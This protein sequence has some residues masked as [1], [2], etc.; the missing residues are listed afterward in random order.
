MRRGSG[1]EPMP[2]PA[3]GWKSP[4][5]R[6]AASQPASVPIRFRSVLPQES[7]VLDNDLKGQLKAYL[8]RLQRPVSIIASVDD[9]DSSQEMLALLEVIRA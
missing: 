5:P 8:E 6:P 3:S 1:S 7:H 4:S 2:A 9:G